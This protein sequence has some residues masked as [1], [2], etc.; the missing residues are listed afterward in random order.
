MIRNAISKALGFSRREEIQKHINPKQEPHSGILGHIF[1][2]V[3]L[4]IIFQIVFTGGNYISGI[5]GGLLNATIHPLFNWLESVVVFPFSVSI[6]SSIYMAIVTTMQL[7]F[8][9][10]LLFY[11]LLALMEDSGYFMKASYMSD[12]FMQSLGL[13]GRAFIPLMMGYG[14]TVT[15]I[16]STKLLGKEKER[17]A[18]GALSTF[19]PCTARTASIFGLISGF[20]GQYIAIVIYVVDLVLVFFVGKVINNILKIPSLSSVMAPPKM[21]IPNLSHVMKKAILNLEEFA[22]FV[23]PILLVSSVIVGIFTEMGV[24]QGIAMS[25]KPM[26]D[27]FGLPSIAALP[28]LF[29]ILRKELALA[30]LVQVAGTVDF[31]TIFTVK[32]MLIYSLIMMIYVPC[33]SAMASLFKE[34]KPVQAI[35]IIVF[36]FMVTLVVGVLANVA[37]SFFMN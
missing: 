35:A 28:L 29:G 16:Y 24:M 25:L 22:V 5:I 6:F 3:S 32:Q 12:R 21:R 17:F 9:Y 34:Y 33:V 7:I 19:L 2:F 36:N 20:F 1:V 11:I 10:L 31:S 4:A 18:V 23:I 14:C 13:N 30:M 37:L 27:I 8:A 15:S 26:M